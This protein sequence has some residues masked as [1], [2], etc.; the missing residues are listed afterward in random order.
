MAPRL[1]CV[2]GDRSSCHSTSHPLPRHTTPDGTVIRNPKTNEIYHKNQI[3]HRNGG[4]Y[5]VIG[6]N[7]ETGE[8][9]VKPVKVK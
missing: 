1:V 5:I 2:Y 8:P 3:I 6:S 7:P 9:I 4:S